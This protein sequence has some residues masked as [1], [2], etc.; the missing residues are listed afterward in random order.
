MNTPQLGEGTSSSTPYPRAVQLMI[1]RLAPGWTYNVTHGAGAV[2]R[3]PTDPDTHK[4]YELEVPVRSAALR[5]RSPGG[6]AAVAVYLAEH[7]DE[8][9]TPAHW[10]ERKATKRMGERCTFVEEKRDPAHWHYGFDE[11]FAWSVCTEVGCEYGGHDH[12]DALPV[13]VGSDRLAAYVSAPLVSLERAELEPM[14]V[15]A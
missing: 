1:N 8:V 10:T 12:P 7:V 9:V 13:R 14:A 2:T 5:L 6:R 3:H 15:A 4:Q 11:A